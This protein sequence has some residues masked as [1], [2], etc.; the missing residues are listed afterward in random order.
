M[1]FNILISILVLHNC[2][3]IWTYFKEKK[4]RGKQI[5]MWREQILN[6][7]AHLHQDECIYSET[8]IGKIQL[9]VHKCGY[10]VSKLEFQFNTPCTTLSSLEESYYWSCIY[11][12]VDNRRLQYSSK[13]VN[14]SSAFFH[15]TWVHRVSFQSRKISLANHSVK[16]PLN[17]YILKEV[18]NPST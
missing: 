7:K 4:I 5:Q 15:Y 9:L 16:G 18:K 3:L 10:T 2:I 11:L 17:T 13:N 8:C 12:A 14:S 6:F 1:F